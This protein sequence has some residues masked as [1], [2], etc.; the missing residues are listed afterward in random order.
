MAAHKSPE[1]C[2]EWAHFDDVTEDIDPHLYE[3]AEVFD[4][5]TG[6]F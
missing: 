3:V 1:F 6:R 5:S 2:K 4:R